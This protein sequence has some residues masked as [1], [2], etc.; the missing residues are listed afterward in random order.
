MADRFAGLGKA[1][2]HP[3]HVDVLQLRNARRHVLAQ[4]PDVESEVETGAGDLLMP[5]A[6]DQVSSPEATGSTSVAG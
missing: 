4:A 1:D 3:I 6:L 5:P 2:R